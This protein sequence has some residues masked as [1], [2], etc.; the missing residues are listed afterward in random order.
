[1]T[2]IARRAS[3]PLVNLRINGI[4]KL[5]VLVCIELP[6]TVLYIDPELSQAFTAAVY[7]IVVAIPL[8][9]IPTRRNGPHFIVHI[10][11]G[12]P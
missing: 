8:E 4:P 11:A 5:L 6:V 3:V 2:G 12:G 1:M 10:N 9:C 7:F